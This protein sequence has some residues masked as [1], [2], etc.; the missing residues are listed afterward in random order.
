MGLHETIPKQFG[1]YNIASGRVTFTVPGEF[2]VDLSVGDEKPDSQLFLI[3]V[4][5][6]YKPSVTPLPKSIFELLERH[7]N[8][9]LGTEKLDGLYNFLHRFFEAAKATELHRQTAE[10]ARGRWNAHLSFRII[11]RTLVVQYWTQR[12]STTMSYIEVGPKRQPNES[13]KLGV[14]WVREDQDVTDDQIPVDDR[15]LSMEDLIKSV[16]VRH[17]LFTLRSIKDQLCKMMGPKLAKKIIRLHK[18]K[19]DPWKTHL[20]LDF[21]PNLKLQVR[22]EPVTGRFSISGAAQTHTTQAE[23]IIN[24]DPKNAAA[25]LQK[26]RMTL[27]LMEVD[28]RARYMGWETFK[29]LNIDTR[30]FQKCVGLDAKNMLFMRRNGWHKDWWVVYVQS[31]G[32]DGWWILEMYGSP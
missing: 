8:H 12:L 13:T 4:R 10:M 7:A 3:D 15:N 5:P 16:I 31:E 27:G 6:L 1:G 20:V 17:T 32:I 21:S 24:K 29:R 9:V 25:M 26:L 22:I 2:E 14:R 30:S 28:Q 23:D 11:R 19:K 18:H